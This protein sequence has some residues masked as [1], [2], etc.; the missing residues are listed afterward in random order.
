ME[1][2]GVMKDGVAKALAD[3]AEELR[4]IHRGKH[5]GVWREETAPKIDAV[6]RAAEP[7]RSF[8]HVWIQTGDGDYTKANARYGAWAIDMLVSKHSPEEIISA[9]DSEVRR[10]SAIYEDASP[11]FGVQ[12]DQDCKI[13]GDIALVAEPADDLKRL[14]HIVPFHTMRLPAGTA[15]L[16]QRFTVAPAFEKIQQSIESPSVVSVTRPNRN[17]RAQTRDRIRLACILVS[18]GPVE[19]PETLLVPAERALF[20]TGE[21]NSTRRPLGSVPLVAFPIEA[22]G[23]EHA[24]RLLMAFQ[25]LDALGRSIDRLG[26]SRM[27]RSDVDRVIDLGMAAEIALMHDMSPSNTEISHKISTR[28]AWLLGS[29]P[30]KRVAIAKG[31]RELYNARSS[32]VH[33]GKLSTKSYLDV[34]DADRLVS[35]ALLAILAHGSF[36]DWNALTLGDR[37]DFPCER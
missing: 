32:A 10:N 27:A 6:F 2:G 20:A 34:A 14:A 1:L 29:E 16:K 37:P 9:F 13:D 19:L 28:V 17:E 25:D 5:Y 22:K 24:Y 18:P 11:L 35:E 12:L 36:P 4:N 3:A 21:G 8:N 30:A 33:S 7:F 15:I 26:R 23:V 31:M